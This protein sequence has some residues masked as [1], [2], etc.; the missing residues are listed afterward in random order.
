MFDDLFVR[1]KIF[2]FNLMNYRRQIPSEPIFYKML[3]RQR[4]D[5]FVNYLSFEPACKCPF[6]SNIIW[7][8]DKNAYCHHCGQKL[9]WR[10]K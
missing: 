3:N 10:D 6:C 8:K 7:E 9:F 5:G 4:G 1:M 2:L